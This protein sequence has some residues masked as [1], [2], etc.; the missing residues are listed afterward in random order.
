[1]SEIRINKLNNYQPPKTSGQPKKE[2]TTQQ[3]IKQ[4]PTLSQKAPDEV[5]G[6]MAN[7]AMLGK[8]GITGKKAVDVNKYV[9]TESKERIEKIMVAFEANILK[10]AETAIKEFGIS[11]RAASDAAIIGFN[12]KFLV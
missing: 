12:R 10:T 4:E 3:E 6:F 5:L 1:M 7:Q 9:D 11:E 2:E 8:A